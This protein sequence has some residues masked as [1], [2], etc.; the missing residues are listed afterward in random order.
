MSQGFMS[1]AVPRVR[2]AKCRGLCRG[3][4][5]HLLAICL[6]VDTE[7]LAQNLCSCAASAV[8]AIPRILPITSVVASYKSFAEGLG[9]RVL[10]ITR[11]LRTISLVAS[12]IIGARV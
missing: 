3:I 8:T 6:L 7:D 4:D 12:S 11:T 10:V 2:E 5:Y 1:G 9:L